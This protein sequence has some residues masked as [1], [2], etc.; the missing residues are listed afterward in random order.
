MMKFSK[1]ML[2][3]S[4]RNASRYQTSQEVS[5]QNS[6]RFFCQSSVSMHSV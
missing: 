2:N 1:K 5:L 3:P 4:I 6:S